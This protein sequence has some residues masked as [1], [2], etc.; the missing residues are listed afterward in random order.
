MEAR[1]SHS[2]FIWNSH[3]FVAGGRTH[4]LGPFYR[5][6]WCLDLSKLDK[7]V[8]LDPYP[9]PMSTTGPFSG[10]IMLVHDDRAYLFTGRRE[11]DY[12]DLRLKRWSSVQ[13]TYE[14]TEADRKAGIK[15]SWF[16]PGKG[17]CF[18]DSTQHIAGDKLYVFGGTHMTTNVG[19]NLFMELDLKT[20]KWRRLDG[21]PNTITPRWDAPGPR[22]TPV[23]WVNGSQD[24]IYLMGGELDRSGGYT[25]NEPH[26]G[27]EGYVFP[28]MWSWDIKAEKWQRERASGNRPCAR[29]EVAYCFVRRLSPSSNTLVDAQF[30]LE[31]KTWKSGTI[32]RV[33][34]FAANR[35]EQ[36]AYVTVY[37]L[38][39]Y[40]HL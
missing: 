13:T 8:E 18:C 26:R 20:K 10:W 36:H 5:D 2:T 9:V 7:W 31:S 22:K 25:R 37:I 27:E 17:R 3:L 12:Y 6:M 16:Y 28:D 15:D 23:S 35:L 32:W 11:L 33:L 24:R 30:V 38:C 40:V 29:S 1:R 39:R 14:P 34:A 21:E 4:D 19:C